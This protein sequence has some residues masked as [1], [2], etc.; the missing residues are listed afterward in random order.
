MADTNKNSEIIEKNIKALKSDNPL[1]IKDTL[2]N[3]RENGDIA[4]IPVLIDLLVKYKETE[5]GEMMRAFLADIKEN[6]IKEIII[7]KLMSTKY[8][9]IKKELLTICWESAVDF[10]SHLDIFVSIIINDEFNNSFEAL[11]VIENFEENVEENIISKQLE[12]LKSAISSADESRKYF[13][14]ETILLLQSRIAQD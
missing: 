6:S 10:S 4:Y 1:I 3:I 12:S 11:T 9:S 2:V 13:L 14:H 8:D 7:E 5:S